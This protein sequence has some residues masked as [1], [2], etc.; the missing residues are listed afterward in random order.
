M[1]ISDALSAA[2][3]IL[4]ENGVADPRR[5][6]SSLVSLALKKE[7]VF[8]VAH[9]EYELTEDESMRL[10]D[11]LNRRAKREPLQYITGSQEFY[12]LDFE[13]NPDVLIPRPETEIL[14]EA[15]IKILSGLPLSTFCEVGVGSGC[16][17]VS[18]LKA[19]PDTRAVGV[20]ISKEA[21]TIAWRNAERHDVVDALSLREA[22]V[23]EG[24]SGEFDLMVSNPP[25][26]PDG[27][28][29]SLQ[30]EVVRFEPLSALFAGSDGLSIIRRIID[31][32]PKFLK[33][34]GFLLIEIGFGQAE[35]VKDLFDFSIWKTVECL[36]DHQD[37]SRVVRSQLRG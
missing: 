10:D 25:Y 18:I 36:P 21:L 19:V 24:L 14:V 3:Q 31:G 13:V 8:L 6:A 34:N 16:V 22:N 9:P 27:H 33:P 28:R 11:V 1:I 32:T 7:A 30:A 5:E 2:A 20:D 29:E 4:G 12:G 37:I 17:A 26:I 23:F 35:I 15:A